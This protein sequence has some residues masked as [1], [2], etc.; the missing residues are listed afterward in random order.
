MSKPRTATLTITINEHD[1]P[2]LFPNDELSEAQKRLVTQIARTAVAEYVAATSAAPR[3]PSVDRIVRLSEVVKI[4][5][6]CR[7]TIYRRMDEGSFPK[8]MSL[9][10]RSVGWKE[11]QITTWFNERQA[12]D[13]V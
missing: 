7:S 2:S 9:G 3:D 10:A 13:R 6:L 4:T 8:S 1:H 11:S 12:G 5:G